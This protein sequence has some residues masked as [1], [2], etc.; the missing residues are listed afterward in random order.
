MEAVAPRRDFFE[1]NV[2]P[3]RS[4][5]AAGSSRAANEIHILLGIE[6]E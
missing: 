6:G 1:D 3:A 4:M 5:A 2:W